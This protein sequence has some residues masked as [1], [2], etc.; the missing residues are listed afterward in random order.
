MMFDQL[1]QGQKNAIIAFV[2]GVLTVIAF[3]LLTK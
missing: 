1:T 2:L 3:L